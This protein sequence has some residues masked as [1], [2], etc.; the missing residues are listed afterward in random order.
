MKKILCLKKSAPRNLMLKFDAVVKLSVVG[1]QLKT[2]N[3]NK[4]IGEN[5]LYSSVQGQD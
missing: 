1:I 3:Y 5:V 2:F 4:A